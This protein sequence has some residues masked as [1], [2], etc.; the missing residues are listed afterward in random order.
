MKFDAILK[1][2]AID[3]EI[4]KIENEIKSSKQYRQGMALQSE[5]KAAGATL[6]RLNDEAADILSNYDRLSKQEAELAEK[7]KELVEH[8]DL[9]EVDSMSAV[10]YFERQMSAFSDALASIERECL[11]QNAKIDEI[12]RKSDSVM[13]Q[14]REL[15]EKL[16]Q[17]NVAFNEYRKE[18]QAKVDELKSSRDALK[19]IITPQFLQHYAA[20]RQQ[21][22]K[23]AFVEYNPA[24]KSCA[25]CFMDI[26]IDTQ[27]KLKNAGDWTE[28]PNCRRI[29]YIKD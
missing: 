24:H 17:A 8:T 29:L 25:G 11:R 16:K 18:F 21:G 2:Q 5:Y 4:L 23:P 7:I 22:K 15:G 26:S 19:D 1:Y 20:L 10:E 12:R 6:S 13:K 3:A 9:S 28:C 27:N 14:G